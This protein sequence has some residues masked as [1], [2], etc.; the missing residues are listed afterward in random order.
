MYAD[1]MLIYVKEDTAELLPQHL[2]MA[3]GELLNTETY[4]NSFNVLH[5]NEI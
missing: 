5:T 4:Q 1:D 2:P 3:A